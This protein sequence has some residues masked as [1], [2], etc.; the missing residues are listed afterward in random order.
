M[1]QSKELENSVSSNIPSNIDCKIIDEM[2]YLRHIGELP[3]TFG[4]ISEF[5]LT[6]VCHGNMPRIDLV[7]DRY[8]F[9]SIKD[10]ERDDRN[11]D[12]N[13]NFQ[14]VGPS[15]TRPS[16]MYTALKSYSFKES[17]I[18]YLVESWDT[19]GISHIL[20]DKIVYVTRKEKCFSFK[21]KVTSF[22]ESLRKNCL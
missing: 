12:L 10:I 18:D 11:A 20:K 15:Q 8:A 16:D 13:S 3:A 22:G 19:Q 6:K 17:L 14:I 7:F 5:I 1:E 9:P 2:Y 4:R 21:N